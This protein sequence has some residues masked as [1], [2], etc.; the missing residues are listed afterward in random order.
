MKLKNK[1]FYSS[2]YM[3]TS[4]E[5]YEMM[6]IFVVLNHRYTQRILELLE[7]GKEISVTDLYIKLRVEQ[8]ICSGHL[9]RMRV[10]KFV[11]TRREGKKI[12]YSIDGVGYMAL[13]RLVNRISDLRSFEN[14]VEEC[15]L[16]F[17]ALGNDG[18]MAILRRLYQKKRATVTDL[19]KELNFEQSIVSKS[20]G[21]LREDAGVVSGENLEWNKKFKIFKVEIDQLVKIKDDI[22]KY[23][24]EV[25]GKVL[26]EV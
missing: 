12:L 5:C 19:R 23:L 25:E 14:Q 22:L 1:I 4:K 18:R 13:K 8:S 6:K 16:L 24:D 20:L 7:G 11:K 2:G 9:R 10:C 17:R 3:L 26:E 15:R 21:I